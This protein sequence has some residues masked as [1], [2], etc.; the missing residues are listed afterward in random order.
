MVLDTDP[1]GTERDGTELAG[2]DPAGADA[3]RDRTTADD[4]S[5]VLH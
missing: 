3:L 4:G 1:A 5:N 2:A